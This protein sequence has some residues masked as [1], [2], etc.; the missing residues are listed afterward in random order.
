MSDQAQKTLLPMSSSTVRTGY[1]HGR[2]NYF[3]DQVPLTDKDI[4]EMLREDAEN[5]VFAPGQQAKLEYSLGL[6]LGMLSGPMIP[7]YCDRVDVPMDMLKDMDV[8]EF[9]GPCVQ[10]ELGE[11]LRELVRN[12]WHMWRFIGVAVRSVV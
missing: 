1:Q 6:I 5:G 8:N 3:I 2:E 10:G 4:I 11:A 7:F 12:Y 9:L